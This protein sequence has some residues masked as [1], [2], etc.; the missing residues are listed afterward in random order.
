MVSPNSAQRELPKPGEWWL[1]FKGTHYL[2][3]DTHTCVDE[4]DV[5]FVAVRKT[6]VTHTETQD[7]LTLYVGQNHDE[8]A[9]TG[10]SEYVGTQFVLYKQTFKANDPR[11]VWARPL[12]NFMEVVSSPVDK[13]L[14][15][16]SNCY[17][18]TK[19]R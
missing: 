3:M 8:V 18:F 1:H 15:Q 7:K 17:R 5:M 12:D 4:S 16:Y 14:N 6:E 11:P 19:I 2:I 10:K 9:L 13:S